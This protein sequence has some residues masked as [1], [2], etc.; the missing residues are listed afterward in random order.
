MSSGVDEFGL[1][2]FILAQ[3]AH[4]QR[5]KGRALSAAGEPLVAGLQSRLLGHEPW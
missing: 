3:A 1:S 5:M 2:A 4:E